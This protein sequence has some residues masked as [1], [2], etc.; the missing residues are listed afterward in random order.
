MTNTTPSPDDLV[1]LDTLRRRLRKFADDYGGFECG[2]YR[3]TEH[4]S[5][6]ATVEAVEYFTSGRRD[7]DTTRAIMAYW[8][9]LVQQAVDRR[10]DGYVP[11]S[12]MHP[13]F[14]NWASVIL[15]R[16]VVDKLHCACSA[17]L[18]LHESDQRDREWEAK[19]QIE[20][21][22]LYLLVDV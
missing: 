12:Y 13:E 10:E 21:L 5:P 11:E 18:P 20:R 15:S 7:G 14:K 19:V 4:A 9:P 16:V 17:Y 6:N 22:R 8:K 3:V 2:I 1:D